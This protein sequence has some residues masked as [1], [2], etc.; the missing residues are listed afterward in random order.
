MP[1][2]IDVKK[3]MRKRVAYLESASGNGVFN[4]DFFNG[5]GHIDNADSIFYD[6]YFVSENAF[7]GIRTISRVQFGGIPCVTLR[8][9]AQKAWIIN[10]CINHIQKKIKP[11]LKPVTDRNSRGFLIYKK[12]EDL[13]KAAKDDKTRDNITD[14]ICN[15]GNF[16]DSDRDSFVKYC[17]KIVRDSLTID[18]VAT[19]LQY[20]KDKKLC[21]FYAVDAA[22]IEKVIHDK[23]VDTEWKYIQVVDGIPSAGYTTDTMLFDFENPRTDIYHSQYG[24]SY[25]EQ[26]VDLITSFINT[27]VYNAGNFTENKLPK[28]MLL[29]NG[30]ATSERVEAMEDYI[31]EIMSG[32]PL[33]Q[34]RIPIIPA[35]DK[36]ASIEWKQ[37][38]GSNRE[39][40]FQQ[41]NDYLTSAVVA[42]FGCS[43][44]EL[45]IQSQKSQ[46][47]F[48]NSG[49]D[50]MSASK[51]LLL[52]DLL[53]F[54]ESYINKIVK[55]INPDYL[56]EFVGYEKDNP[57]TVA[58]LD[59]KEVR[60]W[61]SINEKRAEKGLDPIDLSKVENGA[62]LPMNVQLVQMF[63]AAQAQ[64]GMGEG[65]EEGEGD[66][67]ENYG[68]NAEGEQSE[69]SAE[70]EIEEEI[71]EDQENGDFGTE[72]NGDFGEEQTELNKSLLVRI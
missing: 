48:E 32:G 11:F 2:L 57:N 21:A 70:D 31:A 64:A 65:M 46:T 39:M 56:F 1:E 17:L 38:N 60:T 14:F 42:M 58:D 8:K 35:G 72:E 63:Q 19:E 41:W 44:D 23:N 52:G 49:A 55:K 40:E 47:M 59:E 6:P 29:I 67:W 26:A 28:G 68:D 36:D 22:T 10:T 16:E 66:N 9:V 25:V 27:F 53:T 62:D 71:K 30:D 20:T 37:L 18:Q 5:Q 3:E 45:G 61:K 15:C 24:Y 50:R 34:W 7:H 51:S 4:K 33:N 12:G 54:L 43:M 13:T 69:E